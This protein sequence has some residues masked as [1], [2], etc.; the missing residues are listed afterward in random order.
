M[1]FNVCTLLKEINF[2][3]SITS[4]KFGSFSDC[5]SLVKIN[6]P[7]V[8]SIKPNSFYNCSSITQLI[9]PSSVKIIEESTFAEM[10]NLNQI[11]FEIFTPVSMAKPLEK[12]KIGAGPIPIE[13][14][15]GRL[16]L[17][18]DMSMRI[19]K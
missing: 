12:T 19:T 4:I 16:Y 3:S 9:I 10:K 2:P 5:T 11:S 13:T 17:A 14:D 1:Q 7:S 15:K 6:I 8:T 18:L